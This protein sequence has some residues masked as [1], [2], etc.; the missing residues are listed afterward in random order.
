MALCQWQSHTTNVFGPNITRTCPVEI[1]KQTVTIFLV[2]DQ[3]NGRACQFVWLFAE[4]NLVCNSLP[5]P[6]YL[7]LRFIQSTVFIFGIHIFFLSEAFTNNVKVDHLVTLTLAMQWPQHG[8]GVSE[9]GYYWCFV[10]VYFMNKTIEDFC[11][12][13]SA[14]LSDKSQNRGHRCY[15]V[16]IY[17]SCRY[18]FSTSKVWKS[19]QVRNEINEFH[20]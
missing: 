14:L 2:P 20:F 10:A 13:F 5:I 11:T 18:W 16:A 1:W 8:H 3:N 6:T 12:L 7:N 9:I 17:N 4:F 19:K 15:I